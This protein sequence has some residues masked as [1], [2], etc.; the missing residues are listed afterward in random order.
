MFNKF[1]TSLN[2][3][4]NKFSVIQFRME[5]VSNL[6]FFKENC[7]CIPRIPLNVKYV[8]FCHY[9]YITAVALIYLL[10]IRFKLRHISTAGNWRYIKQQ[11][12][13]VMAA[14]RYA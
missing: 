1:D 8:F 9:R 7:Y 12:S 2:K 14:V 10:L 13:D 4:E 5:E 3:V 11:P 6:F